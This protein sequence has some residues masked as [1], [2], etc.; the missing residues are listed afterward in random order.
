MSPFSEVFWRFGQI[1][2][3]VF[4]GIVVGTNQACGYDH[5]FHTYFYHRRYPPLHRK[6]A[7][8]LLSG[9]CEELQKDYQT[10][11]VPACEVLLTPLPVGVMICSSIVSSRTRFL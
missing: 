7:V 6:N 10:N 4:L 1:V 11:I 3:S 8:L 2:R 9:V 5:D